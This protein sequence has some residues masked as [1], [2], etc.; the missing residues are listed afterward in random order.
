MHLGIDLKEMVL[1][2]AIA[3]YLLD[4][5]ESLY[6]IKQV[7]SR[8]LG[9]D[10]ASNDSKSQDGQLNFDEPDASSAASSVAAT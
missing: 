9:I 8:Y 7:V 1:D 10:I 3:A 2:T 5:S 4:P 6:E